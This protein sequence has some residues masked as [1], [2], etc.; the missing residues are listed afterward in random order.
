M[1]FLH[2]LELDLVPQLF[3]PS[4]CKRKPV[5]IRN[6]NNYIDWNHVVLNREVFSLR[7]LLIAMRKFSKFLK[8]TIIVSHNAVMLK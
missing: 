6:H 7:A 8:E 5:F 4:L 2:Y 3:L 1:A